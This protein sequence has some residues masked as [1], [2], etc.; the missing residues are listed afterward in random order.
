[1]LI[2]QPKV[3]L[4]VFNN[5]QSFSL[6]TSPAKPR[7]P[8]P[9][10][11]PTPPTPAQPTKPEPAKKPAPSPSKPAEKPTPVKS[12]PETKPA[13]PTEPVKAVPKAAPKVAPQETSPPK[14][15]DYRMPTKEEQ[16]AKFKDQGGYFTFYIV[17]RERHV[18]GKGL[19]NAYVSLIITQ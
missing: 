1:M 8:V 13:K 19:A 4:L 7:A 16:Y 6:Y 14:K 3:G 18:L 5:R 2:D 17:N 12:V 10:P 9:T 11:T 15:A